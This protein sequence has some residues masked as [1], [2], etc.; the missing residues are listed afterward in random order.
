MKYATIKSYFY[1]PL[2]YIK[3]HMI[4]TVFT[5]IRE[6]LKCHDELQSIP[7]SGLEK[8]KIVLPL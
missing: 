4:I 7:L 2:K 3:T 6:L 5:S 1:E 8:K